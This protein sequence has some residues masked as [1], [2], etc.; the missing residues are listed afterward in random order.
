MTADFSDPWLATYTDSQYLLV[1]FFLSAAG[2]AVFSAFI[3]A[4]LTRNEVGPRYRSV[5]ISRLGATGIA[6]MS[7]VGIVAQSRLGYDLL[8]GVYVPNGAAMDS[9]A[10]RFLGWAVA[11]PLVITAF[12]AVCA[13]SGKLARRA[14][15]LVTGLSFGMILTA[16][17]GA[18]VVESADAAGVIGWGI[19]GLLFFISINVVVITAVRRST[20]AL[21]PAA[22][23]L[24]RNALWLL[25]GG[26]AIYPVIYLLQICTTGGAWAAAIQVVFCCADII[27]LVGVGELIHQV[28]KLR[29]AEDV[30]AGIDVHPEAI[31]ISS[32]KMSDAG[33]PPEVY[34][35]QRAQVHDRRPKPPMASAMALEAEEYPESTSE[36]DFPTDVRV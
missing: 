29:T 19:A 18:F 16:Y 30:R 33:R 35:D 7:Y 31:W 11:L 5:S 2:L 8:D 12:I 28:A 9:F 6:F 27:V 24:L 13:L 17:I 25:V 3:R 32:V 36:D 14:T 26:L 22:A 1:S 10:L 21:T 20:G 34:L 4:W 15:L 23:R